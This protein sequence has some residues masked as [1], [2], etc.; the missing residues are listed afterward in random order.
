MPALQI[1]SEENEVT[2]SN[3]SGAGPLSFTFAHAEKLDINVDVDGETI[4]QS[5]WVHTP[6]VADGGFDGG[7]VTLVTPVVGKDVRIWRDMV[8]LRAS[9]FGAGGAN[10]RAIDTEFNRLV[11]MAQDARNNGGTGGGIPDAPN[12]GSYYARRNAGWSVFTPGS[13]GIEEAPE[14]DGIYARQ[15]ADWVEVPSVSS[16]GVNIVDTYAELEALDFAGAPDAVLVLGRLSAGDGAGGI[17]RKVTGDQSASVTGDALKGVYVAPTS[18]A[19][20]AS[21]VWQRQFSGNQVLSVW[22]GVRPGV[23]ADMQPAAQAA[24]DFLES[25]N[26]GGTVLFPA[27]NIRVDDTITVSQSN[28]VIAGSGSDASHGA[29]TNQVHKTVLYWGGASNA[30]KAVVIVRT[31]YGPT[32]QKRM[33]QSVRDIEIDG[34]SLAGF[35]LQLD[36]ITKGKFENIHVR[37]CT[38]RQYNLS[39][40]HI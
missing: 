36:S 6:V 12:N 4:A 1:I 26:S 34:R 14:D 7:T 2:Y 18:D 5:E 24:V 11:L 30:S 37:H 3:Y 15:N 33:G 22:W 13:G 38:A 28:I 39:L 16:D 21:G 8:R 19:T 31:P 17:F 23:N 20:G 27:G 40:I 9:Q 32:T 10:P 35:G 29:G 25:L